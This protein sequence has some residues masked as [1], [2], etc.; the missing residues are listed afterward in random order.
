[1]V[2]SKEQWDIYVNDIETVAK[3]IQREIDDTTVLSNNW[4]ELVLMKLDLDRCLGRM[5]KM[6]GDNSGK[7][8]TF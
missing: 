7:P 1:M 5:N 2:I 8:D 3:S 6:R 4:N